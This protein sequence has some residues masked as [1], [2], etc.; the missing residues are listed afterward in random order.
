MAGT[1]TTPRDEEIRREVL[2]ELEFDAE[3]RQSEIGV[4]V[5]DQVV[6]LI[7]WVDNLPKRWAAERAA[8]RVRGVKAVANEIEVR[9]P[10]GD[11]RTDAGIAASAVQAL[12]G[13]TRVPANA[14]RVSVSN[15]WVTLRGE[16]DWQYQRRAAHRVIRNLA[17][18]RGVTNLITVRSGHM[19]APD[20]VK[21]RIVSAFLRSAELDT[22]KITVTI[23]GGKVT[24]TG[25]VRS[26]VEAAEAETAAWSAPGVTEVDNRIVVG[27]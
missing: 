24:L 27:R 23:D 7:G 11:E 26:W 16:V 4:I 18:V 22:R 15:G 21:D 1:S 20:D 3:V 14:V 2:T 5:D 12:A 17:G 6:T 19:P 13:D 8:L 10:A 25:S 9:L